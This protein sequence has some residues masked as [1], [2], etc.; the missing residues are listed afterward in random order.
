[1]SSRN[2]NSTSY[3]RAAGSNLGYSN[4]RFVLWQTSHAQIFCMD[5][6]TAS[7]KERR[8]ELT[9]LERLQKKEEVSSARKNP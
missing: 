3:F 9:Q 5:C 6:G 4:K 2:A 7:G 8:C 1:M